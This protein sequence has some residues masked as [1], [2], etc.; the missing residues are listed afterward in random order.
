[1]LSTLSLLLI[2]PRAEA[3][4]ALRARFRGAPRVA[5]RRLCLDQL[6]DDE[7][8][9]AVL[10]PG[11]SYGLMSAGFDAA[12]V[13]RFGLAIESEVQRTI[14]DEHLGEQPIGSA[15]ILPTRDARIP[16]LIHAPTMRIPRDISETE[17]VYQATR[18]ALVAIYRTR[19][20]PAWRD[21]PPIRRLL[22]PLLGAGFGRVPDAEAARQIAVAWRTV[23]QPPY[24]PDWERVTRRHR[25]ISYDGPERR[26]P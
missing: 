18:A 10:T 2:N 16:W 24:P 17:H 7:P 13:D 12:V 1:M 21:V 25:L 20:D 22:V 9:D 23:Q 14:L 19:H 4:R 26:I 11:N 5:I 6:P 15:F 8:V 3:V